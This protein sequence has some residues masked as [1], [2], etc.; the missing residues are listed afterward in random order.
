[1]DFEDARAREVFFDVHSGLPREGP[2][3]RDCT[4]RALAIAR[5]GVERPRVL[6]I[7]CGPG[8]QTLDLAALLPDARITA[9]DNHA[10]FLEEVDRRARARGV[11]DRIETRLGDMNA[12][13]LPEAS[14]DLLWCEGAAYI[15][16]FE[17]ALRS[18]RP[19]LAADGVLAL[20]E[21]V[22]LRPDPPEAVRRAFADYPEM[23]D[24]EGCR[25]RV[26]ACGYRLLGDFVLPDEAWL[27]DYYLPMELRLA[28]LEP[29]YAGDRSAD[30]VLAE[31]R[32]E[33]RVFRDF[34]SYFGYVLLVMAQ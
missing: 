17:N 12:I 15:M 5:L 14:F 16:G 10:P 3:S 34:S 11:D 25:R 13:D 33:I 7:G 22:W 32:E 26:A 30:A 21:A 4:A 29:K 19:L 24:V 27:T 31:C 9:L 28:D 23:T 1:M 2:G 20:S 18:W 6:D 8:M